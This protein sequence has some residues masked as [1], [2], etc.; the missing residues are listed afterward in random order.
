MNNTQFY[1]VDSLFGYDIFK[2]EEGNSENTQLI[3]IL[4]SLDTLVEYIHLSQ[5]DVPTCFRKDGT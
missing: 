3:G 4:L 5:D 2:A 1:R